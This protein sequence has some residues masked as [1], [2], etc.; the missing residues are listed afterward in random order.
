MARLHHRHSAEAVRTTTLVPAELQP[1]P[2]N[3]HTFGVTEPIKTGDHC[4]VIAGAL[5]LVG[6][7]AR[8]FVTV[9]QVRGERSEY[10]RIWR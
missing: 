7:N 5:G 1:F 6:P 10:D 9:G 2:R 3:R 8:K 4:E